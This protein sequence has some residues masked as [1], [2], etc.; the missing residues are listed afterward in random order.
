MKMKKIMRLLSATV[1]TLAGAV[2]TGCSDSDDSIDSSSQQAAQKDHIVTVRTV[3][4]IGKTG[5]QTR[6]LN[7]KTGEKTFAVN[8]QIRICYNRTDG[9]DIMY[10]AFSEKLT[11]SDISADGKT[12]TFTVTLKNPKSGTVEYDYPGVLYD[13]L[14]T[15]QD[16]TFEKFQSMFD[17]ANAFGE[18]TVNGDDVT[19][20]SLELRNAYAVLV[21]RVLD[22]DG[23][24]ITA[25]ISRL[26]INDG[27]FTYTVN[28]TPADGPIYV[29]I[30]GTNNQDISVT[31]TDGTNNYTK[32]L[33][34]KTYKAGNIYNLGWKMTL[35]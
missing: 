33:T 5:D 24:D 7:P 31:A 6:A 9:G 26:T 35:Q 32:L 8:D 28:R 3:V 30:G 34:G 10:D 12:A 1:I 29:A 13:D 17:F 2:M 11:D 4:S 23:T 18:M 25:T 14:W 19:M 16:G 20:P 15:K 22:A 21:L 27:S